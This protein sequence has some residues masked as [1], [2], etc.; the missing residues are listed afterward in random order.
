MS[1]DQNYQL[2]MSHDKVVSHTYSAQGAVS[3]YFGK[4]ATSM[5]EYNGPREGF[6]VLGEPMLRAPE[7]VNG[8][9]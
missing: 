2:N 1:G 4:T 6:N 8:I 3:Q 9:N 7:D 5:R